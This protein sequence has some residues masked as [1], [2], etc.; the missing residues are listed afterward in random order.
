M[1][2]ATTN[3]SKAYT[4]MMSH[5]ERQMQAAICSIKHSCPA[6]LKDLRLD[7]PPNS[8]LHWGTQDQR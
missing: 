7:D 1:N 6:L 4:C 5:D 3:A 2:S 8:G